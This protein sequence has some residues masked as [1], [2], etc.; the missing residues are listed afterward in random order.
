M[1]VLSF[2]LVLETFMGVEQRTGLGTNPRI[3]CV[4]SKSDSDHVT[5]TTATEPL[6]VLFAIVTSPSVTILY[7]EWCLPDH[8]VL[9]VNCM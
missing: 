5:A 3:P 1:K 6:E 9:Q 2:H 4:V 7:I 8:L